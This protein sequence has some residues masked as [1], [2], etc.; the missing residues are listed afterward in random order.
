M[1]QKDKVSYESKEENMFCWASTKDDD[2]EVMD[3]TIV[4]EQ[5]PIQSASS[6]VT[7]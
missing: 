3:E 1:I 7:Q 5:N 2:D 4:M 6:E